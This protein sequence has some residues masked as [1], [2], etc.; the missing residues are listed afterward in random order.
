MFID[1][2]QIFN[3][4]PKPPIISFWLRHWP[5]QSPMTRDLVMQR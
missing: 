5:P 3:I 2:N 1:L 4:N